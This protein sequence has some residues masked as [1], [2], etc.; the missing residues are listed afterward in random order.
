MRSKLL[1]LSTIL[2]ISIMGIGLASAQQRGKRDKRVD[3]DH[4]ERPT[5][6]K[7]VERDKRAR[8]DRQH[9]RATRHDR[10][11]RRPAKRV[12]R[13]P[14]RRHFRRHVRRAPARRVYRP[15]YG[16]GYRY[17]NVRHTR[18]TRLINRIMWEADLDGDGY[19][20][21]YEA[22]RHYRLRG[23]FRYI[24]RNWD[25][26]LSRAELRMYFR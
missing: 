16:Y 17:R 21:R 9:R 20:S 1:T 7:R 2:A 11:V 15:S 10:A 24:N 25:G 18:L 13:R 3:R 6:R 19:I 5:K 26:L 22:R 4:T 23:K 14:A 8:V 12:V